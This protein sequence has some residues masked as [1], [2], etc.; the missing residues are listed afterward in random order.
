M[1]ARNNNKLRVKGFEIDPFA[2]LLYDGTPDDFLLTYV[3]KP[4]RDEL[5]EQF[6]QQF[7]SRR[8]ET[9]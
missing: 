7:P 8:P 3:Y 9:E 5:L 1:M 4:L 2:M 6:Y